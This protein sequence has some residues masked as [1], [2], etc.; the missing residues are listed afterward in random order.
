VS[1]NVEKRFET[2]IYIQ[3]QLHLWL[4][5]SLDGCEYSASLSGGFIPGK[6]TPF[7]DN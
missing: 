6:E 7:S 1:D 5:S 2:D 4:T 3:V